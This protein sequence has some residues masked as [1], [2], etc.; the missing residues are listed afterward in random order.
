MRGHRRK[1]LRISGRRKEVREGEDCCKQGALLKIEERSG[2]V[3]THYICRSTH[4]QSLCVYFSIY[5]TTLWIEKNNEPFLHQYVMLSFNI[6]M[7]W[8][9]L[10]Y[11]KGFWGFSWSC[12]M[13]ALLCWAQKWTFYEIPRK[14][15]KD[16]SVSLPASFCDLRTFFFRDMSHL[17]VIHELY[18]PMKHICFKIKDHWADNLQWFPVLICMHLPSARSLMKWSWFS[19]VQRWAKKWTCF[20]KQQPGRARQKFL[21]TLVPLFSPSL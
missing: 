4:T 9:Y 2:A 8:A 7:V 10:Q 18:F 15:E 6:C 14:K 21:A 19:I 5:T 11:Y 16:I 13:F 20:A 3:F 12:L 1:H 17:E